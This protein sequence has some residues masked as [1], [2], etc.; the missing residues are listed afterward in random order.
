MI[1]LDTET[2]GTDQEDRL[3]QLA[4]RAEDADVNEYFKPPV[5]I[6]CRAMAI[7]HIT[8][9]MVANKPV[10]KGSQTRLDL[11]ERLKTDI[12][13]A[14]NAGF[15]VRML[16]K[17][18]V[19]CPKTICTQK[20]ACFLDPEGKLQSYS[21]QYLRYKL[22]LKIDATAHDA[23]G[24]ILVLEQ[25]FDRFKKKLSIDEMLEL[26][27]KPTLLPRIKFGKHRGELFKD[28]PKG[29]LK[30]LSEQP[31]MDTNVSFTA[32]HWR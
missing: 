25:I 12:M 27:S 10:F 16:K 11:I 18:D 26:S 14:H 15:D 6:K 31:D 2:T 4:Y 22:D 1:F 17:E 9:E 20:V 30:W 19:D 24:D 8:E 32:N 29:Y 3:C 7:N 28:L 23:W 21:E 13:V 5:R